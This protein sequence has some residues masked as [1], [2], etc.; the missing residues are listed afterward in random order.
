MEINCQYNTD[1]LDKMIFLG[2]GG[3]VKLTSAGEFALCIHCGK[4]GKNG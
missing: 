4:P 2:E 1:L 3:A